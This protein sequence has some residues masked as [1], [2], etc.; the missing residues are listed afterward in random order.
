M[1]YAFFVG[2]DAYNATYEKNAL[3]LRCN[4]VSKIELCV[5]RQVVGQAYEPDFEHNNYAREYVEFLA[6]CN[7]GLRDVNT[8]PPDDFKTHRAI[9]AFDLTPNGERAQHLIKNASLTLKFSFTNAINKTLTLLVYTLRSDTVA[10]DFEHNF[11]HTGDT[12][13]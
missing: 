2:Q 12:V 11:T 7:R 1:L 3:A 5:D 4:N 6:F 8:F 13:V 9:Y 10:F